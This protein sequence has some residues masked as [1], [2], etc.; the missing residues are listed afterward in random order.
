[1]SVITPT[2]NR[3]AFLKECV[4]SVL[5]ENRPTRELIVVDDASTDGTAEWLRAQSDPRLRVIILE[6]HSERCAA[7]NAA[8]DIARGEFLYFLDHDDRTRPGGLAH[9]VELLED[10]RSAVAAA[11]A[12]MLFD[13]TE[14]GIRY[15]LK[16][17]R[18]GDILLEALIY[19]LLLPT[20]S[21]LYRATAARAAGPWDDRYIG[22]EDGEFSL[23]VLALG[24]A[25]ISPRV[26]GEHRMG[27]T[28]YHPEMAETE[29][30]LRQA[31]R[32]LL[33]R[34]AP[35]RRAR[36][37]RVVRGWEDVVEA[38]KAGRSLSPN[39]SLR[40]AAQVVGDDPRFWLGR[41]RQLPSALVVR[42]LGMTPGVG[43]PVRFTRKLRR[44]IRNARRPFIPWDAAIREDK[45]LFERRRREWRR[46]RTTEILA[47]SRAIVRGWFGR[48]SRPGMP[49][50]PTPDDP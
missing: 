1:V 26:V 46:R 25:V 47:E 29:A 5:R 2:H 16:R 4:A 41:G 33:R 43:W 3:L 6:S 11:G 18:R 42:A 39:G 14:A 48:S 27:S 35:A 10:D 36:A 12:L 20:G 37:E 21:I 17:F 13:E 50:G 44:R 40:V 49:P 34:L 38:Y 23:R 7:R 31:Q 19:H 24:P 28:L 22:M 32:E 9:L 45:S 8:M 30:L 15:G